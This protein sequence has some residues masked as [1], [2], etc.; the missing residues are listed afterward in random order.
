M[1]CCLPLRVVHTCKL[2]CIHHASSMSFVRSVRT[3]HL[4][5]RERVFVWV[6]FTLMSV[7]IFSLVGASP[8][9][10]CGIMSLGKFAS[11]GIVSLGWLPGICYPVMVIWVRL[12]LCLCPK[13]PTH[14]VGVD[15]THSHSWWVSSHSW[16]GIGSAA[17]LKKIEVV[18]ATSRAPTII[19]WEGGCLRGTENYSVGA[20]CLHGHRKL[21]SGGRLRGHRKLFDGGGCED[22]GNH[23]ARAP[24]RAPEIIWC[25]APVRAP[26]NMW[27]GCRANCL[28]ACL[29]IYLWAVRASVPSELFVSG[30]SDLFVSGQFVCVDTRGAKRCACVMHPH[31]CGT[32]FNCVWSAFG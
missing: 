16:C 25:G 27:L 7:L 18:G 11:C 29:A 19:W 32:K 8:C 24:V 15:P 28:W 30:S 31:M 9:A 23:S 4:V 22:T 26:T 12:A 17:D 13:P 10:S 14:L 5:S 6:L 2:V 21:F 1:A 20:G 3:S